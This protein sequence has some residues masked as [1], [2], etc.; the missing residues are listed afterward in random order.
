LQRRNDFGEHGLQFVG[1][2]LGDDLVNNVTQAY[3]SKMMNCMRTKLFRN[4]SNMCMILLLQ[5][6][7]IQEKIPDA[8]KSIIF[9]NRPILLIK[10]RQ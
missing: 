4:Q 8:A 10:K 9:N 3:G 1:Q 6:K 5:Q 7:V 2:N